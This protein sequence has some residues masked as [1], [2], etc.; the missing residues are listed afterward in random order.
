MSNAQDPQ[1]GLG[2]RMTFAAWAIGIAMV[3]LLF[4]SVLERRNNPNRS[5]QA[6]VDATGVREVVLRRNPYGHYVT[7]GRINDHPVTFM[8]DT[9]ATQVAMSASLADRLGLA[10]LAEGQSSTAG[11]LVTAYQTRLDE[12]TIGP[13]RQSGVA[14]SILP[15]MEDDEVLLGMSFIKN[16]ELIQREDRLILRQYPR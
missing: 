13:I 8:V 14:A 1:R 16:L 12:V 2:R 9:G 10:R 6:N 11:G 5:P 4:Q 15:S 7:A 3:T